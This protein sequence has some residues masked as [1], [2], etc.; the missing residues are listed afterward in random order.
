MMIARPSQ[1]PTPL[2]SQLTGG[3]GRGMSYGAREAFD[4][5]CTSDYIHTRYPQYKVLVV[6]GTSIGGAACILL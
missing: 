5:L 1:Q 3:R 6:M 2:Q 4:I